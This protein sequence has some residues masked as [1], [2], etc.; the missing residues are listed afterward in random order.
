MTMKTH[1]SLLL[2]CIAALGASAGL[3]ATVTPDLAALGRGGAGW[4]VPASNPFAP[5]KDA[6]GGD[7][8]VQ[9]NPVALAYVAGLELADGV[10]EFDVRGRAGD[11]SSFVGVVFH[12]VDG[13]THDG[14][15][16]RSFNFGHE[17]PEKRRHA[18]Q[19]IA[20]PDWP[21]FRL[22]KERTDEFEKGVTPEPKSTGWFHARVVLAGGR[23]RVFVNDAVEPSLDVPK[24]NDRRSGRV[25]VWFSGFGD[26]ANLRITPAAP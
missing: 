22:R 13:E 1:L 8:A 7:T 16:F 20:H 24:L 14:V 18:V 25:G 23:V 15:Y 3:A 19:Y 26:I 4:E 11:Q 10:I 6:P 21:W 9:A 2:S 12:G 5:A 17:N